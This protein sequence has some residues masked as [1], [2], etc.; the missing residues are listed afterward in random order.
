MAASLRDYKPWDIERAAQ[1]FLST[2]W[3]PSEGWVDV[4][5]IIERDLGI[6]IDY[7]SHDCVEVIGTIARRKSD[8]RFVIVVNEAIADNKPNLYRFTLAQ[9][10]SHFL[11]HR[12]I[13]ESITTPEEARQFHNSLTAR[14]YTELEAVVN[15]CAGAILMPQHQFRDAAHDAYER[16]FSR[17]KSQ[18]DKVTP[19]FLVKR[20]IDDLAKFYRVSFIAAKIRLQNWP[21]RLYEDIADSASREQPFLSGG[22]RRRDEG[23]G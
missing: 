6:G 17:I 15:R 4:E 9:E 11:L 10:L 23:G 1:D 19:D 5:T 20:V 22:W 16:W 18:I 7:F 14:Q 3:S 21:I 12:D 8:G 13:L 2:W